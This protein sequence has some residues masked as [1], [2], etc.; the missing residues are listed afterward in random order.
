L[1][2]YQW[3]LKQPFEKTHIEAKLVGTTLVINGKH[4]GINLNREHE[5]GQTPWYQALSLSLRKHLKQESE[6]PHEFWTLRPDNLD[7]YRLQIEQVSE[8]ELK[9]SHT[10]EQ[11]YHVLIRPTGWK[12]PF[13]KGE[14]WFRK[15]DGSFLRYFGGSGPPGSPPTIVEPR[16]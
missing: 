15:S 14:Y 2:T 5:L 13:W 3:S 8:D 1:N 7:L 9:M 11:T 12:A 6:L 4:R 16:D 10:T